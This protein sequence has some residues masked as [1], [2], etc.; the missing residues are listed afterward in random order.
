MTISELRCEYRENPLGIGETTPRLSWKMVTD[1][2]G[3]RQTAYQLRVASTDGLSS[4]PDLWDSGKITS[5]QS[6]HVPYAGKPLG[7]GQ[8][9]YW[10]VTVWDEN[11][12]PT[13]SEVV[14]R[15]RTA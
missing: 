14:L 9:A 8:R 12:T 7:S 3:A 13:T 5:D 15:D 11:N 6:V 2:H 1:R 10:N 4:S